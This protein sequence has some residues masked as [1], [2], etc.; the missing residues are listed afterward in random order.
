[1]PLISPSNFVRSL[2]IG[3]VFVP[4]LC[5][6]ADAQSKPDLTQ[7]LTV[8]KVSAPLSG[9]EST[10]AL[11]LAERAL[12]EKKLFADK[13]M[14]LTDAHVTRDTASE[15]KGVFE[16]LAL[17]L[18][19]RYEGD[20]TIEVLINLARKEV[21]AV[22]QLPDYV[23]PISG[24]E[25]AIAKELALNDPQLKPILSPHLDRLEVDILTPRS[26]SPD[27]PFFRH[28]VLYLMFRVGT[29]YLIPQSVFVDLTTEKILIEPVGQTK[30]M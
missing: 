22:K 16:R 28:R 26:E 6:I 17:L 11:G 12:K 5:G 18:Y 10:L 14:Y 30:P 3:F 23:A 8:A 7:A 13:K 24:E 9:E 27:D 15:R 21:V 19:Y 4:W 2:A 25:F 20:L 29:K 1:M